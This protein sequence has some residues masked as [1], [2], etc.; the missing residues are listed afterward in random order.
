[1]RS[2]SSHAPPL[3][4]SLGLLERAVGY[5]R[6]TLQDVTPDLLGNPTPCA[7]WDLRGL[8]DHMVESLATLTE[9]AD[10]GYVDLCVPEGRP[11]PVPAVQ[12]LRVQA[13]SLLG[14]WAAVAH[15]DAVM[16]GD[17]PIASSVLACAGALEIAV[18]GWDVAQA[19][20]NPRPIPTLLALDLLPWVDVFVDDEDRP[21]RFAPELPWTLA[22]PSPQLLG[23]LGRQS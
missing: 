15:D 8:L 20:G 6:S 2:A 7:R 3:L 4:E 14:A 12:R 17:R 16:I 9:G 11:S 18:H 10:L 19:T 23:R 1:V 5:T 21:E 13:C 22:G